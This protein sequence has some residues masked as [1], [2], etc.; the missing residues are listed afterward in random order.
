LIKAAESG[1]VERSQP[2]APDDAR[3]LEP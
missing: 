2:V 1:N 3:S